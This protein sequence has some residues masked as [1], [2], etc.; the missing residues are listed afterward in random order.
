MIRLD[1]PLML[2]R[3]RLVLEPIV[4]RHPPEHPVGDPVLP[5]HPPRPRQAE[6]LELAVV[7]PIVRRV[8]YLFLKKI[9]G[10]TT[11]TRAERGGGEGE[12]TDVDLRVDEYARSFQRGVQMHVV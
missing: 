6:V 1:N 2:E 9:S 5:Y 7:Q 3:A 8:C 11:R 4:V 12:L 10:S